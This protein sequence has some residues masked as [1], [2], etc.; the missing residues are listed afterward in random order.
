MKMVTDSQIAHYIAMFI[1]FVMATSFSIGCYKKEGIKLLSDK[2]EL[3]YIEDIQ[4]QWTASAEIKEPYNELEE[5]EKAV[6]IAKL[7]K[8]LKELH[9]PTPT[10]A[11]VKQVVQKEDKDNLLFTD[12]KDALVGLGVP[13]RKAKADVQNV[14]DQNPNIKTVQ[15]FITE[16][17]K[18]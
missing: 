18:R 1:V 5:L 10:R 14:F 3:G 9:E 2:F 17:G 16:Y 7:K 6:K 15:Q 8:Q 4:P 11:P 13:A 12:C